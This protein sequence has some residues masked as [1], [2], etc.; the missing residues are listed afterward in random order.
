MESP[1]YPITR[2]L[3][4]SMNSC[5]TVFSNCEVCGRRKPSA[6]RRGWTQSYLYPGNHVE[7]SAFEQA[8]NDDYWEQECA[9]W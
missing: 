6:E 1:M 2:F 8:R 7:Q 5:G 9:F 4:S 3:L